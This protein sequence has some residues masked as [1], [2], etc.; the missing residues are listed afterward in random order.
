MNGWIINHGMMKIVQNFQVK[1]SRVNWRGY[2]IP[3]KL[4]QIF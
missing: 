2:R 4:M 3:A 1:G